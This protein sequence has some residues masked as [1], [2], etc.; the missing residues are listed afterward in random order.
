MPSLAETQHWMR[1]AVVG[2]DASSIAGLLVGGRNPL[3]RLHI[4]ER[5]YES[6]LAG[7]VV[8]KFPATAWLVG[9]PFVTAAA[10]AFV[11]EHPPN[12]PCIAEYGHDFPAFV[13]VRPEAERLPYLRSFAE[14]E[15]TIGLA[16]I[17]IDYPP[18]DPAA[19]GGADESV[20]PDLVFDV[21][22]GVWYL[23]AD[24]PVDD[25]M[26]LYLTN[27]APGAFVFEP[28]RMW[29][30]IRGARGAFDLTR[31]DA[32]DFVFRKAVLDG[33]TIGAAA[34]QALEATSG[35]DPARGVSSVFAEA[36]VTG[37]R[38]NQEA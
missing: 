3:E 8:G 37:W 18:L 33:H 11:H 7:A 31:L 32:G 35:F 16:S 6:S 26:K 10:R 28:A 23:S 38:V 13:S 9:L 5:H 21:Q 27:S 29:L 1:N 19:L 34:E 2:G 20:L 36:L 4:H 22:P 12:A 17:A 30:Q 24:W 14:L 15:W 25:L